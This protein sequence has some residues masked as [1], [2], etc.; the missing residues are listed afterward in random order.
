MG[1]RTRLTSEGAGD[2]VKRESKRARDA[3]RPRARTQD[4]Q[5]PSAHA[6]WRCKSRCYCWCCRAVTRRRCLGHLHSGLSG[7]RRGKPAASGA[8]LMLPLPIRE[9]L[10]VAASIFDLKILSIEHHFMPTSQRLT[11][12]VPQRIHPRPALCRLDDRQMHDAP[13]Y[14]FLE[15]NNEG[16]IIAECI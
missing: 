11:T 8:G 5:P 10:R 4:T 15:N 1:G 7:E 16:I 9:E 2:G 14:V 13:S 6:G 3:W 12:H